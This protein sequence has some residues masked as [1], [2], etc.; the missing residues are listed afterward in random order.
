MQALAYNKTSAKL[1]QAHDEALSQVLQEYNDTE[2]GRETEFKVAKEKVLKQELLEQFYNYK[3]KYDEILDSDISSV[4]QQAKC[5]YVECIRTLSRDR[6]MEEEEIS[7]AHNQA[8]NA[9]MEVLVNVEQTRGVEFAQSCKMKIETLMDCEKKSL[10]VTN[11]FHKMR[12]ENQFFQ[13]RK[14]MEKQYYQAIMVKINPTFVLITLYRIYIQL[15][16]RNI[17]LELVSFTGQIFPYEQQNI[18]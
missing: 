1:N 2:I 16:A 8:A 4:V 11:D 10:D 6:Y 7:S 14:A 15:D 3:K 5:R 13:N 18:Y 12:A 9:A 17:N